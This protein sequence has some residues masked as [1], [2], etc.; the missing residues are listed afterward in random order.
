METGVG[1]LIPTYNRLA[2][3]RQSLESA[4]AQDYPNLEIIVI[5]NGS[6]DGTPDYM[7]QCADP[8]VRYVVNEENL[9]LVGSINKG[10]N[11]FSSH[12]SWC[13]IL[14]DDD[15]LDANFVVAMVA[16]RRELSADA[17]VYGRRLIVGLAGNVI[18]EASPAP[19]AESSFEYL[20]NR[21]RQRRETYLTGVFF[22]RKAF[23]EIGGYPRFT[24]GMATDDAF[25]FALAML[26]RLYYTH[27][28]TISLR[29][30]EGAESQESRSLPHL[31]ALKEFRAYVA[32]IARSVGMGTGEYDE[33]RLEALRGVIA[34]LVRHLASSLWLRD[35]KSVVKARNGDR[36]Q[37]IDELCRI[38][39]DNDLPF[40]IRVRSS[41]RTN[42]IFGTFP[43]ACVAYRAC[44]EAVGKMALAVRRCF[45]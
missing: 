45:W 44:W 43:E 15:L 8:R 21:S 41:V 10:I 5:D 19:R 13:T 26:D 38:V 22:S 20:L 33:E 14:P 27:K 25:I 42:R 4:L 35:V 1:I 32:H 18:R 9:R 39:Q 40:S 30:H 12:V 2:F 23:G 29:V 28:A 3:L 34:R 11:L 24:T 31:A 37:R 36:Q 17:V 7:R 6:T 16:A